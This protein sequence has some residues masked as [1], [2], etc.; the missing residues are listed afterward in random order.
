MQ[1][2]YPKQDQMLKLLQFWSIVMLVSLVR[3]RL[4]SFLS[5][6]EFEESLEALLYTALTWRNYQYT[7]GFYSFVVEEGFGR[8]EH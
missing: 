3:R 2:P 7:E 5:L 6:I 1:K 4:D 8:C